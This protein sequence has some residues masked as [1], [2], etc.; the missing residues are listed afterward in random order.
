MLCL[1]RIEHS[2]RTILYS[3]FFIT[4]LDY[5]APSLSS[6]LHFAMEPVNLGYSTKNIPTAKPN[7]Y[8]KTVLDKTQT[9]LQRMRWK[10]YHF[11]KPT[12]TNTA[13][14]TNATFGFKTTKSPP[15]INELREFEDRMLNL[16]QNIEFRN[17]KNAFPI[18]LSF[19]QLFFF[20][21]NMAKF[22]KKCGS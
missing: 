20:L 5:L 6:T 19:S 22:S 8:L 18:I 14:T 10:A 11:L 17:T 16:V 12:D 21:Q 1:R 4:T 13:T 3:I 9:F 2:L 15:A 7:V